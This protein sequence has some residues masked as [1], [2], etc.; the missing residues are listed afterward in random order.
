MFILVAFGL[1]GVGLAVYGVVVLVRTRSF[2]GRAAYA[3]GEIVGW[4]TEWESG[5]E[6]RNRALYPTLRFTATDGRL[7][8]TE[9]EIPLDYWPTD[10]EAPVTVVFD[11]ANPAHARLST[12]QTRGYATGLMYVV[13][14]LA[15]AVITLVRAQL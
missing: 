6:S 11:P 13:G 14:G 4:R 15:L 10:P 2:L 5:S 1:V 12:R 3:E 9:S 7:I 8:E